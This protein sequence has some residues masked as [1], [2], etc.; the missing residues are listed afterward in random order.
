MC[1]VVCVVDLL[2]EN[3]TSS[4]PPTAASRRSASS[5]D[6]VPSTSSHQASSGAGTEAGGDG[7]DRP[8]ETYHLS[9]VTAPLYSINPLCIPVKYLGLRQH[10]S[11]AGST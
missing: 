6:P 9:A 11:A 5:T 4:N 1:A 8:D 3:G 2:Q 10:A 7:G